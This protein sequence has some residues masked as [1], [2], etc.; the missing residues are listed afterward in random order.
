MNESNANRQFWNVLFTP[1]LLLLLFTQIY[2][3][4]KACPKG[5]LK[6]S[7]ISRRISKFDLFKKNRA[8]SA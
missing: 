8:K 5:A 1:P 4:K 7:R 3:D 2:F 6:R